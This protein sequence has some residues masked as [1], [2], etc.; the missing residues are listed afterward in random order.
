MHSAFSRARGY[1]ATVALHEQRLAFANTTA[2]PF[3]LWMSASA[4][5]ANFLPGT[6][7]DETIAYNI[8][9][10]QA[11]PV[12][13]MASSSD[14]LLG[15]LSQEFAA[16]GGGLG[17]PITPSNTR[18]VPQSGEG[19][20]GVQ[21]VRIGTETVFVN[22]TGRRVIS[23]GG[24][25]DTGAYAA[26]DLNELA[27]HLTLGAPVTRLAWA[28]NPA[29]LLWALRADGALLSLTYRREQQLYG[30]ARHDLGG[31]VESIAVIP[32]ATGAHDELWLVV[33]RSVAGQL[34]RFIEILSPPFEPTGPGDKASMCFL[35]ASLRYEGTAV[36]SVS[37]LAH[38]EGAEVQVMIDGAMHPSRI[39][40][41][42]G[43]DLETAGSSICVGLG[44]TS[45]LRSLHLDLTPQGFVQDRARRI[46]RMSIRVLNALGGEA[47][48]DDMMQELVRRDQGDRM[49]ASPPL[50]TGDIDILPPSTH[51]TTPQL[52]IR[53]REPLPL[54]ILSVTTVL[55][56]GEA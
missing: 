45:T 14:L 53:Q 25:G 49:D 46:L 11:D 51:D 19:A 29:A 2:Q 6:K 9:A 28:R 42:G 40:T 1:P 22:R 43:I 36:T 34:R 24:E 41:G 56:V 35:D 52:T 31:T 27:G 21:P 4:D 15:T 8:A 47:G 55:Q 37:G 7:D 12:R 44:Y 50:F 26:T 32:S 38:L 23:L 54:D 5:Y 33:R 17:D 10:N 16:F 30:W 13:W 3:G 48:T 39:V 20:N 18:I